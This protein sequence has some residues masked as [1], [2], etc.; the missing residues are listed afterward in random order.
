M[1][2]TPAQLPLEA[3]ASDADQPFY[4]VLGIG[5]VSIDDVLH[6]R[7]YL[8]PD[9]K[10]PVLRRERYVG[11]MTAT[12]LVAAT[13]LGGRCG[14]A[15]VLGDDEYSVLA[16]ESLQEYGVDLA[17]L[18]RRPDARPILAVVIMPT[19]S[20]PGASSTTLTG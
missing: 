18:V 12:A 17:P 10:I 16:A 1:A 11:R 7:S 9:R 20:K 15:G 14:Y 13:R 3:V 6:V 5:C 2:D 19:I 4:D 8:P